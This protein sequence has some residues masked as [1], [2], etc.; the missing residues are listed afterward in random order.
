MFL[1]TTRG[2]S[3]DANLDKLL[4]D[5]ELEQR[6]AMRPLCVSLAEIGVAV[7]TQ[8]QDTMWVGPAETVIDRIFNELALDYDAREGAPLEQLKEFIQFRGEKCEKQPET[9][10]N[11]PAQLE[12]SPKSTT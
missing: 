1:C 5:I 12:L 7:I 6:K 4:D 10:S 3:L 9:K 8:A 11:E 2:D